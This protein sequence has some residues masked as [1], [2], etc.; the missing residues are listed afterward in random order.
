L[1]AAE[2]IAANAAVVAATAPVILRSTGFNTTTNMPNPLTSANMPQTTLALANETGGGYT[3]QMVNN[4]TQA[5]NIL[6]SN[7]VPDINGKYNCYLDPLQLQ[8]LFNDGAF[9]LLY[10]GAYQS[11]DYHQGEVMDIGGLRFIPNNI[12]PQQTLSGVAIHRALVVGKG[13]LVEGDFAG[14]NAEDTITPLAEISD[15]DGVR[16]ITRAP[17]DRLQQLVAQSWVWI[18]GFVTPSDTTTNPNTVP[19]ASNANFKRAVIIESM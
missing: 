19:T 16:M 10:R 7:G 11:R 15:V 3:L 2:S 8:G 4:C 14:Q 18:G 12:A 17:M 9:Q 5:A 1:A 13:A 6:R